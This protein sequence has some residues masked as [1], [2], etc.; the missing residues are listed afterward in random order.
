MLLGRKNYLFAG[1]HSGAKRAALFYSFF[2][3]CKRH[4]VNPSKWLKRV[5]ELIPDYPANQLDDLLPQN[6]ELE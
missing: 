4:G 2:G 6:L 5:L 1:S 3:T